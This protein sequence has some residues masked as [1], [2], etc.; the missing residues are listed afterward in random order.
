MA[1]GQYSVERVRARDDVRAPVE[2]PLLRQYDEHE[3]TNRNLLQPGRCE[4]ALVP[5][6]YAKGREEEASIQT[7][8]CAV[9]R[10]SLIRG[11]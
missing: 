5:Q 2:I 1:A 11:T 7:R 4:P 6:K 8:R 3:R 9:G 10:N